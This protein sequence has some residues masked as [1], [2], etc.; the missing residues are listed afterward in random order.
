MGVAGAGVH[1]VGRS[2]RTS[3]LAILVLTAVL[4]MLTATTC[5]V[6]Q[7]T[8][9]SE[10][11]HDDSGTPPSDS[12]NILQGTTTYKQESAPT[13]V[14][15]LI[16]AIYDRMNEDLDDVLKLEI[17]YVGGVIH[18]LVGKHDVRATVT[19]RTEAGEEWQECMVVPVVIEDSNE[20]TL[21][22]GSAM[23]HECHASAECVNTIG[24]YEC[25]CPGG[26]ECVPRSGQGFCT[27]VSTTADCC[28]VDEEKRPNGCR[29]KTCSSDCRKDFRC[30]TD[31]CGGK[32]VYP[33]SCRS[34]RGSV[35]CACEGEGE[36]GN[37]HVCPGETPIVYADAA[38]AILPAD[39]DPSKICGCQ[40]PTVDLCHD[41]NCGP[42][43]ECSVVDGE[44]RCLCMAG[45]RDVP[46]V[47]CMDDSAPTLILK[48]PAQLTMKQCDK[49]VESGVEVVDANSENDDRN[50]GVTYSKPPGRCASEMGSFTVNYTLNTGWTHPAVQYIVRHVTVEDV[51]ECALD[52]ASPQGLCPGCRPHCHQHAK[53]E[54]R[55]GTYACKCPAC[56][57]GDG[58]TPFVPRKSGTTPAGYEGGT[59]CRDTCPPVITL[60]GDDPLVLEVGIMTDIAGNPVAHKNYTS[61]LAE[62]I[63][64]TSGGVLCKDSSGSRCATVI[65]NNGTHERVDITPNL[66]I[67]TPVQVSKNPPRWQVTY[68][69]VDE[70]GNYAEPKVR[71]VEIQE[72]TMEEY[73]NRRVEEALENRPCPKCGK[74]AE[75]P[76]PPP[77]VQLPCKPSNDEASTSRGRRGQNTNC[78]RDCPCSE[79]DGCVAESDCAARQPTRECSADGDAGGNGGGEGGMG[80]WCLP[81]FLSGAQQLVVA[82]CV[83]LATGVVVFAATR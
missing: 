46:G 37:G 21:P 42:H 58:F 2:N 33:E 50:V 64:R 9:E 56:M 54:N 12:C 80:A 26:E 34:N 53:C 32:C 35:T 61:E 67:L 75:C 47:G 38:G 79:R 40:V 81:I 36:V 6:G 1:V 49:Y 17:N 69:A 65:D 68:E 82:A 73:G 18:R 59:G 24:S 77:P 20:C 27:G 43:A 22:A 71:T 48:G 45:Y 76:K 11:H 3:S 78:A 41:V 31:Q 74:A 7:A 55:V 83:L 25:S 72:V 23:R 29:D 10:S 66:K 62:L 14:S 39:L 52:P 13:D 8:I 63:S 4:T 19:R 16:G 44:V 57:S 60:I 30:Y 15:G 70:A 5:C 28:A 51:D